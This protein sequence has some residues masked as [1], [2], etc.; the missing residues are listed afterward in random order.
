M[1]ALAS[2]IASPLFLPLRGAPGVR[3][4]L[5][6]TKEVTKKRRFPHAATRRDRLR[7]Q[8]PTFQAQSCRQLGL[9]LSYDN[10]IV[11]VYCSADFVNLQFVTYSVAERLTEGLAYASAHT[12]TMLS[13]VLKE[14]HHGEHDVMRFARDT[15]NLVSQRGSSSKVMFFWHFHHTQ[16]PRMNARVY[17]AVLGGVFLKARERY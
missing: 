2:V 12:G 4:R 17:T 16:K 5:F 14:V 11:S 6:L 15:G 8:E 3:P 7:R 9:Q 13:S 10:C 1:I